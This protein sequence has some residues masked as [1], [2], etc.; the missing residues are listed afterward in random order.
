[1][2]LPIKMG[3][4]PENTRTTCLKPMQSAQRSL[5]ACRFIRY[6]RDTVAR[7]PLV[8]RPEELSSK[9]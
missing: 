5:R 8:A 1:M 3:E 7:L 4:E 6:I 2:F 9:C